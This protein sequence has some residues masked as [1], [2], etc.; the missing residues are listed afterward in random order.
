MFIQ[1]RYTNEAF[2]FFE[3]QKTGWGNYF[4]LPNIPLNTWGGDNLL[5][6][7][8]LAF[9]T[10]FASFFYILKIFIYRLKKIKI[11]VPIEVVFSLG[12]L[13]STTL[14]ILFFRGGMLFSLNRFIFATIF[15]A[16]VFIHFRT[17]LL[18]YKLQYII[19][20]FFAIISI[21]VTLFGAYQHILKFIKFFII[22]LFPLFF[23]LSKTDSKLSNIYKIIF[24][25]ISFV[26]FL[27]TSNLYINGKW[28]G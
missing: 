14:I 19:S 22:A 18:E 26:L 11:N 24:T 23:M 15:F 28:V 17:S 5:R 20:A 12:Y 6:F 7:D 9:L 3:V 27:W 25:V 1:Y 21:Y 13:F 16:V 2:S 8:S 4:R 10:G